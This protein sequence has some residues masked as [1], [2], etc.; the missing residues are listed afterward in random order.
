VLEV[1][2]GRAR[3]QL[4]EPVVTSSCRVADSVRA[5]MTLTVRLLQADIAKGTV[6]FTA[7][8]SNTFR[9]EEAAS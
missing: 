1:H 9:Q 5:G 3:I 6:E 4:T 2:D 8:D 7:A